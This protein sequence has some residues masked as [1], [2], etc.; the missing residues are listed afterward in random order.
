MKRILKVV[1]IIVAVL[2]VLVIAIP[3]FIDAN[4][5]KPKLES[6]L[7]DALGRQVTVGNISLSLLSGGVSADNIAIADDP[8]FSKSPFV[9]AKALKVGVEMIPL[10][11]SRTINITDLTLNDPQISLVKSPNGEKWNFSSLGTKSGTTESQPES[12]GSNEPAK[13]APST[14]PS[15]SATAPA[16]PAGKNSNESAPT[17]SPSAEHPNLTVAKLNVNNGRVTVSQA[18]STMPQRVYD[19]VN[20]QVTNFSFTS[21]FPFSMSADLPSG[22]TMKL[23]GNAGPIN[24]GNAEQTPLE[25][26]INVQHMNLAASGFIDPAAGIAGIADLD[27]TV[28][29]NGHDANV[30]GNVVVNGLKVVAKG[31]PAGKPVDVK[32]AIVHNLVKE[33]GDIQ[34]CDISM[35]KAVAHLTGTYDAHGKVTTVNLKLNGPNMPVDDLEA[36]LPAVGVVLPPKATLKGGNLDV[37]TAS[38]GPVDKLVTTGTVRLQNTQLA[39]FNLG[40]KMAAISALGGKNTGNDTTI[41]NFSSDVKNSPQGTA[42]NNINLTV[43]A[44]G[45]LTGVG[46]VSPTD[47][48]AFKMKA[49]VAGLSVPF[50]IE[51]T[52]SDPKFTPDVKGIATGLLQNVLAGQQGN[53]GQQQQNPVNSVMG[54]FKKKQQPK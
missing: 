8:Q 16:K 25:A 30:D 52:A 18:N 5:F 19:K 10:I 38:S 15:N 33:T 43:P 23:T 12:G 48:L 28:K 27:G 31:A 45:V 7:T 9:Q 24:V 54:L 35:G 22:G 26:K 40:E 6:E 2:I 51:G 50:G 46:T 42:A 29:S 44:I 14:A 53:N 3:F 32:F 17:N 49:D 36:M 1:A 11:F 21:S 37:Q 41:Q 39:N 34:Q 47:Q 20:V 13:T 4:T